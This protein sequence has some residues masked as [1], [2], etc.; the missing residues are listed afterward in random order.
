M[1][2]DHLES[3]ACRVERLIWG[4][5][6]GGKEC[7]FGKGNAAVAAAAAGGLV[8]MMGRCLAAVNKSWFGLVR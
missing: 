8:V 4:V 7:S 6:K 3:W 5:K 2:E 1:R